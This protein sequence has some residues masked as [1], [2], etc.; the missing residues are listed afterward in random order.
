MRHSGVNSSLQS[1]AT[2]KLKCGG[3]QLGKSNDKGKNMLHL[4]DKL[5]NFFFS[6]PHV[7]KI[8]GMMI[9]RG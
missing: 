6:R 1:P 2:A 8:T 4:L 7:A 5:N 3:Y 9:S